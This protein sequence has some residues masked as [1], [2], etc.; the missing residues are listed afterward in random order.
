MNKI[1]TRAEWERDLEDMCKRANRRVTPTVI[2]ERAESSELLPW[3]DDQTGVVLN[4]IVNA[5]RP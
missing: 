1:L 2:V 5:S 3:I 4:A